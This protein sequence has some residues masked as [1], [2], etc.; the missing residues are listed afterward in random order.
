MNKMYIIYLSVIT[1]KIF[2][3]DVQAFVLQN[4]YFP[5]Q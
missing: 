1:I 2:D 5:Q 3:F 4:G